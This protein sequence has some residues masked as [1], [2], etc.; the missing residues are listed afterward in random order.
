[1]SVSPGAVRYIK[2]GEGLCIGAWV[3]LAVSPAI[4]QHFH[5][6][7]PGEQIELAACARL[8]GTKE[9]PDGLMV[10]PK[11]VPLV[12]EMR[13]LRISDGMSGV[14][15]RRGHIHPF[16]ARQPGRAYQLP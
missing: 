1:M 15:R 5:E 16:P 11:G 14:R 9:I 7:T 4:P 10:A 8:F 12:E 6:A 3:A 2:A 13:T